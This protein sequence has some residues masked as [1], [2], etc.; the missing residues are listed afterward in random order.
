ML[1]LE[2]VE[3]NLLEAARR[4]S[5]A[6]LFIFVGKCIKLFYKCMYVDVYLYIESYGK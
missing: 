3:Y 1:F 5:I 2:F 6:S 4:D